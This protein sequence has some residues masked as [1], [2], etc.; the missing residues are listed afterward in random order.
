M[1]RAFRA[2]ADASREAADPKPAQPALLAK[3]TVSDRRLRG[4][5]RLHAEDGI[6]T[7]DEC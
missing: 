1:Y 2:V 3:H 7:R 6:D 4:I 5:I